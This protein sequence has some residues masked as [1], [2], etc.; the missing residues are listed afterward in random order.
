MVIVA[1]RPLPRSRAQRGWRRLGALALLMA[2]ACRSGP[3]PTP[4]A[5]A[6]SRTVVLVSLDG[7][8]ADYLDRPGAVR[9]RAL[10]ARGVR[11]QRMIPAFPS[12]TFPAH[13]TVVTGLHPEHHGIVANTMQD[14]AIGKTFTISDTLVARDPRWWQ[15]EPLWITAE[16]QGVRSAS[17][18]WPGSD[19]EVAGGRPSDYRPYD[20]RVP[21]AA[22]VRQVLAW[23]ARPAATAPRFITLYFSTTDDAGHAH[24]PDAPQVDSA[25]AH[26]DSLIG[27]LDDGIAA[28]GAADRVALVVVAD[29]GMTAISADRVI[30][31]DDYLDLSTVQVID[32]MPVTGL[33]PRAGRED[34]V[35]A[36]LRTAHPQLAVYRKD[37]VP[38][39]FHYSAHP[40]IPPVVLIASEGW[41]ISSRARVTLM[42]PPRGGTH[43]YDNQLPAMGA[44][45]VAAG[46]GLARGRVLPP[47]ASV[48]VYPL[49]A[50]LL[51]IV[52][53]PHDGSLDA[54]RAA[55]RER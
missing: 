37:E 19:Y 28:L 16:R 54:V 9:L 10:A 2:T 35:V 3:A 44:L 17:F 24:G 34:S 41:T 32:W 20:G 6:P 49:L 11:A 46:P 4:V 31:L 1:V 25:I 55:L 48:H 12:K 21:N 22:R 26:V 39:R 45:F 40:R 30:Y 18:Y 52:P 42:G 13:Y 53:A 36:R 38:A 5:P 51:G 29:H 15:G 8:R 14:P 23:L 7:F 50:H 43:G 47:F 27:A 33:A